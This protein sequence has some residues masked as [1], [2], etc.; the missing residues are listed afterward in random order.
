MK[1]TLKPISMVLTI[2]MMLSLLTCYASA[3]TSRDMSATS[4][5][6][7]WE[8]TTHFYIS[9]SGYELTEIGTMVWGYNTF[10]F[11]ED[12]CNTVG[13]EHNKSTAKLKR[14]G[15]DNDFV[16]GG[17]AVTTATSRIEIRHKTSSVIYRI[18]LSGNYNN[19]EIS[20]TTV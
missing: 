15:Y 20:T 9:V 7:K 19:H 8:K 14:V 16:S 11:N 13:W 6:K 1:K 17:T 5:P 18:T 10:L 2:I 4:F 3:E 12:Y